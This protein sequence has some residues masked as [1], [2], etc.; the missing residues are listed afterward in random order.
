MPVYLGYNSESSAL[1]HF[2]FR[3]LFQCN[4]LLPF[5]FARNTFVARKQIHLFLFDLKPVNLLLSSLLRS[6]TVEAFFYVLLTVHHD[7]IV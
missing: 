1:L 6:A 2:S 3:P 7:I 5:T 4:Q